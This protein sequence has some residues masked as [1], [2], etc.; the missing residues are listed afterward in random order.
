ML[1]TILQDVIDNI[2]ELCAD[3]G[4]ELAEPVGF[5]EQWSEQGSAPRIFIRPV[6]GKPAG[7]NFFGTQ[8]AGGTQTNQMVRKVWTMIEVQCWGLP[9]PKGRLIHN[10]DNTELLR[11]IVYNAVNQAV[12]GGYRA[13]R[14]VWNHGDAQSGMYGRALA[15]FFAIEQ[16]IP[17]IAPWET[18]VDL[19]RIDLTADTETAVIEES[20]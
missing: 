3:Q 2:D 11:Q 7:P 10:T 9:D 12:P 14:E 17:E 15:I 18:T 20:P 5:A 6:T 19:Q 8:G 1:S 16:P 13:E 4:V